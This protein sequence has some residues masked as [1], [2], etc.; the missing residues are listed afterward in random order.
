MKTLFALL[1]LVLCLSAHAETN[2]LFGTFT[3]KPI[4]AVNRG[5]VGFTLNGSSENG[6]TFDYQAIDLDGNI[7]DSGA[8]SYFIA[9]QSTSRMTIECDFDG[10]GSC[11]IKYN[12]RTLT[13]TVTILFTDRSRYICRG[14]R[15]LPQ[16]F[17]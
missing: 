6:G 7:Q 3:R 14:I 15:F 2:Y 13:F 16:A 4:G 1:S 17:D 9:S 12:K 11:V 10:G 5:Y 8:G